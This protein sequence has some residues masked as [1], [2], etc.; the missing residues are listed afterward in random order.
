MDAEHHD[1][2]S[3]A[4]RQAMERLMAFGVLVEAGSRLRAEN[5]RAAASR[6]QQR[7][8]SMADEA[9]QA[10]AAQRHAAALSDQKAREWARFV[11]DPQRLRSHLARLRFPDL[12]RQWGAAA[13]YADTDPVA[14]T[15]LAAAEADLRERA[16]GLMSF[17]DRARADGIPRGEAMAGAVGYSWRGS[18]PA[19]PHGGRPP[20]AGEL[21]RL[22]EELETTLADLA[23][24]A[25]PA[26]RTRLLRHL[27]DAGWSSESIGHIESILDR[28]TPSAGRA[29]NRTAAQVAAKSFAA[30]ARDALTAH[31]AAMPA[32]A[33]TA[34]P[35]HRRTR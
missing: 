9:R 4:A 20:A 29:D 35:I 3:D 23:R 1:P 5:Q 2:W 21:I 7:A 16:P 32:R 33:R 22:G 8:A 13:E 18:S 15:V 19:R 26:E 12:A 17:Y 34:D 11:D 10:M 25:G 14:A 28:R 31:P 30:P 6:T 27:E 24:S